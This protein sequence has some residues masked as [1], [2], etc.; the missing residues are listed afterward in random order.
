[1]GFNVSLSGRFNDTLCNS[2]YFDIPASFQNDIQFVVR[3]KSGVWVEFGPS[4]NLGNFV[5]ELV[6]QV[7]NTSTTFTVANCKLVGDIGRWYMV[8]TSDA[9]SINGWVDF[10]IT[11]NKVPT[12]VPAVASQGT[13]SLPVPANTVFLQVN[14]KLNDEKRGQIVTIENVTTNAAQMPLFFG[15]G[16][17]KC[18]TT[19]IG[20]AAPL[21]TFRTHVANVTAQLGL[22]FNLDGSGPVSNFD[23]IISTENV[24]C[25]VPPKLQFCTQ[26]DYEI[27]DWEDAE[28][29]DK[30]LEFL[31]NQIDPSEECLPYLKEFWCATFF[32]KCDSNSFDIIPCKADCENVKS[33]CSSI[34]PLAQMDCGYYDFS[35]T[36]CYVTAPPSPHVSSKPKMDIKVI[37]GVVVGVVG[38]VV[39]VALIVFFVRRRKRADYES[40]KN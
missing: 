34:P 28:A 37:I 14:V 23:F 4:D 6:A 25:K 30:G 24:T 26:V 2:Y 13:F 8:L 31:V 35:E 12:P 18:P 32:S 33:Q 40:V 7:G 9:S 20:N 1:L 19:F 3:S 29:M 27:A 39:I 15:G 10:N 5:E 11:A 22:D 21:L 36:Q 16:F 38:F 17:G